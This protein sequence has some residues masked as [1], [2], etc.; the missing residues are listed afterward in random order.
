LSTD[1]Q[2]QARADAVY[3]VDL[4]RVPAAGL[5]L[6]EIDELQ[7]GRWEFAF[8]TP[9]ANSQAQRHLSV[10]PSDYDSL[11]Q[12]H[13]TYRIEGTLT[14]AHGQSCPPIALATPG[15]RAPNGSSSGGNP[16]YDAPTVRFAFD[17]A[18]ETLFGPCELDGVPGFSVAQS[19]HQTVA[20]TL[21]GDHLFFNGFPEGGEGGIHRRAQWLADCDLNL[22]AEVTRDELDLIQPS[23]LPE[24][25]DGFQLG[26]SPVTPLDSMSDYLRGQLMTQGHMNGEGECAYNRI[27][28]EA[29]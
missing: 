9:L 13:M 6:W 4:T 17:L 14:Q 5:P 10:D 23:A 3:V 19:S 18:A 7:P 27:P 11:V 28:R 12:H 21:H 25:D 16:C 1:E 2:A 15:T 22:D 29:Q 26:G 20:A 24:I 8:E